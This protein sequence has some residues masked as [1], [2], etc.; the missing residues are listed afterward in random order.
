MADIY[1]NSEY[2]KNN[3]D[4]HAEDAAF[5]VKN[6]VKSIEANQI[7]CKSIVEIGCGTGEILRLLQAALNNNKIKF[8]GYDVSKQ[9]IDIAKSKENESLLFDIKDITKEEIEREF[10]LCLVMDVLEHV[11]DYFSLLESIRAIS[12]YTIFHIPLDMFVWSL[13]REDMLIESKKRVGHIHN[14]TEKFILS[15]LED[16]QFKVIHHFYTEPD[17]RSDSFK[18]G[19]INSFKKFLFS[20]SPRF[21]SKTLGGYSIMVV[22]RN[23]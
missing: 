23:Q 14:F 17:Y 11:P 6:I 10:D 19:V 16:H 20:I 8:T 4:W 3:P 7:V 18:G 1:N 13:F 22:C 21:C 2:L 15:I 5:K 12:E 9:A